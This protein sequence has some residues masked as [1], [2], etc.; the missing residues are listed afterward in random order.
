MAAYYNEID[1]AAAATLRELINQK[2]IAPGDVDERSIED[3]CATDLVGYDQCHFFA[4]IGIWSYALRLAG[5]PDDYPVWTGSCPCQPFSPAGKGKGFA[6]ERH[7]WPAFHWLIEQRGVE[8]VFGEQVAGKDGLAWL[9]LVSADMEA[10]DYAVG[11]VPFPAAGIGAPHIRE[12]L[13]WVADANNQRLE[14]RR[15]PGCEC[16]AEWTSGPSGLV[17][18][19]EN[20]DRQRRDG[21][22]A[23]LRQD[24]GGQEG[25]IPQAAWRSEVGR[26]G[27]TNDHWRDADWLGCRDGF[28]RPVEPGASPLAHGSAARVGRL[29]A[30][31]NA[32]VAQQAAAFI[33]S[34]FE[35][36]GASC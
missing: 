32:I 26:P 18:G 3:V 23:L 1:P 15:Q 5:I 29:R 7:L 8:L 28:W 11:A 27:P 4:G 34:Y 14:G 10:M 22:D 2:L 21:L 30:Y 17:G 25:S 6:D 24:A 35:V 19:M 9:D 31:G 12:R 36:R 20:T 16:A 33:E 13:Y